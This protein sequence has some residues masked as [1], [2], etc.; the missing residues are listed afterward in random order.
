MINNVKIEK[1][2]L[3]IGFIP[4]I[5]S[6]PLIYAHNHGIFEKNGLN[7]ELTNHQVGVELKNSWSTIISMPHTCFHHYHLLAL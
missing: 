5:C 1:P 2:D 6:T 4:I 7:V 3:K